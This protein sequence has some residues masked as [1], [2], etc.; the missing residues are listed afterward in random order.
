V[1]AVPPQEAWLQIKSLPADFRGLA[2][3]TKVEK[4][5]KELAKTP[6]VRDGRQRE[7]LFEKRRSEIADRL[8]SLAEDGD[9]TRLRTTVAAW[10]KQADAPEPSDD[11]RLMR[12]VL[13][14]AS[15]TAAASARA[16][17]ARE[18]CGPAIAGLELSAVLRPERTP[19]TYF[20]LPPAHALNGSKRK[21]VAALPQAASAGFKDGARVEQETAFSGWRQ[22]PA[23]QELLQ[24][25]RPTPTPA[26]S[27]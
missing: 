5:A 18:N 7:E 26:T 16:Q 22:N 15:V 19:Q 3:V 8:I 2:D 21:A 6:E 9:H 20:D 23:F 14:G 12:Q 4:R 24:A 11:R 1:H 27:R 17:L 13:A 10:Q 25:M